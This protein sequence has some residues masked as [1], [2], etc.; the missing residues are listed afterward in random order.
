[1]CA[2]KKTPLRVLSLSLEKAQHARMQRVRAAP[3]WLESAYVLWKPTAPARP[4][5]PS[6]NGRGLTCQPRSPT[7]SRSSRVSTRDRASARS[8][9]GGC[10]ARALAACARRA[11][12]V[13]VGPYLTK[14]HS[15]SESALSLGAQPCSNMPA[16]ASNEQLSC[17]CAQ[18]IKRH[19]AYSLVL[20]G[21]RSM[22]MQRVRAMPRW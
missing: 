10:A 8:P 9:S 15:A 3:R 12:L 4:P 21:K 5:S 17:A 11:A 2:S 13:E 20:G 6:V 22:R 19:C 18:V 16:A 14:P 7:R 1:M